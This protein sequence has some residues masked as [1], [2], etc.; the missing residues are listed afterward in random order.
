LI[1]AVVLAIGFLPLFVELAVAVPILAHA[2]WHLY[3]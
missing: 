3:R 1:V 2:R